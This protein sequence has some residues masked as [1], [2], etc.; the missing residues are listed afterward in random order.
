VT[1]SRTKKK[2]GSVTFVGG[3]PGDPG[4]ITLRAVEALGDADVV[5]VERRLREQ[6]TAH[7]RPDVELVDPTRLEPAERAKAIVTPA[8]DGRRVVRFLDGDG[9][10]FA[11]LAEEAEAC[12]RARLPIELVPGVPAVTAIPAYAGIPVTDKKSHAVHVVDVGPDAPEPDWAALASS[13]GTLVLLRCA[14][15]IGKVAA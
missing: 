2:L 9:T 15:S 13:T 14:K 8:K 10:L 7:C 1:T 5:I 4:L 11:G 12:A 3:G 6:A